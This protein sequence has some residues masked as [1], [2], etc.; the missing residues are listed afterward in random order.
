MSNFS[1]NSSFD[2]NRELLLEK[3]KAQEVER[4]FF[5]TSVLS[6]LDGDKVQISNNTTQQKVP[7]KSVTTKPQVVNNNQSFTKVDADD[8]K[9]SF[10]EKTK[11]FAKGLIAPIK[12]MFSTPKNIALTA[13]SALACAAIIGVTGGAAAPVFVAAGLIGGG[14][15]II[16]GIQKQSKATTDAQAKEAWQDMGSGTFTVGVSALSAKTALKGSGT[17]VKGMS[18]IKA[19]GKCIAD[20]PKNISTSFKTAKINISD[21][22]AGMK[23]ATPKT[24]A[25]KGKTVK[26]KVPDSTVETL[27]SDN[28]VITS[29]KATGKPATTGKPIV[30]IPDTTGES[31]ADVVVIE[32]TVETMNNNVP[33]VKEQ[34]L[35]T[36]PEEKLMLP[37]PEERLL[38]EAPKTP[39]ID[40]PEMPSSGATTTETTSG[41]KNAEIKSKARTHKK[42]SKHSNKNDYFKPSFWERFKDFFRV[43]G[44]FKD[45]SIVK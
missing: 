22:V 11:N 40:V 24:S 27:S 2:V 34:A 39:V 8:G 4:R 19:S 6:E 16:K 42:A 32:K 15:Q 3:R 30:D 14:A 33:K 45:K 25:P 9:I 10:K 28:P 7:N 36:P 21:F 43:F 17:D 44:F 38:L 37:A 1:L 18:T 31:F 5:G 23:T 12:T 26:P 20:V 41:I 29:D 35:L 13:V